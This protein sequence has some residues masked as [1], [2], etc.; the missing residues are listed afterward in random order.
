[1]NFWIQPCARCADLYGQSAG[2]PPHSGLALNGIGAVKDVRAEEH[3]ARVKCRAVFA[4][5]FAG[6]PPKQVWMLLNAGQH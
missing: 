4:R 2:E 6:P 5:I 3:Y 1:M